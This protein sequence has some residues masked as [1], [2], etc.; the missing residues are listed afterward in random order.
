MNH[1]MAMAHKCD[2]KILISLL[3]CL[4][5]SMV[6]STLIRPFAICI[7]Q[8]NDNSQLRRLIFTYISITVY[9]FALMSLFS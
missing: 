9:L 7:F 8:R 2:R 3:H 1:K 5:L 4:I 6:L